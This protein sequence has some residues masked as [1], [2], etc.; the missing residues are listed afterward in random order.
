MDESVPSVRVVIV[1]ISHREVVTFLPSNTVYA[2]WA[3]VKDPVDE[4]YTPGTKTSPDS[5]LPVK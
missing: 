3:I 4:Q 1:C 2:S 5:S